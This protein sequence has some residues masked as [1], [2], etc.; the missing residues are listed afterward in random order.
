VYQGGIA[1]SG[2][3]K[4]SAICEVQV[5]FNVFDF[6]MEDEVGNETGGT[7]IVA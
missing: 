5:D 3:V 2:L 6:P 1:V 7:Y 4:P